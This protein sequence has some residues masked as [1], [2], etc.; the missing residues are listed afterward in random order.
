MPEVHPTIAATAAKA[1]TA[2]L[3]KVAVKVA[4]ATPSTSSAV[5]TLFKTIFLPML[6]PIIASLLQKYGGGKLRPYLEPVR[7]ILVLAY[8][9]DEDE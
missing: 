4:A 9:E 5:L 3:D 7:D 6:A 2:K 1:T 8:P